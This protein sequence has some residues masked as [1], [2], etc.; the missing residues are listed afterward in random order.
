MSKIIEQEKEGN[1]DPI[2]LANTDTFLARL[3]NELMDKDPQ[4]AIELGIK[5]DG[6]KGGGDAKK[7]QTPE[8]LAAQEAERDKILQDSM[9]ADTCNLVM[10][11]MAVVMTEFEESQNQAQERFRKQLLL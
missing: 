8:E 2:R 7:I 1:D 6:R 3:N 4:K 9:Q 10:K 11:K 5:Y